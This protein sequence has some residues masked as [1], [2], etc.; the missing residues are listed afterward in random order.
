MNLGSSYYSSD[1]FL[2][3]GYNYTPIGNY[4]IGFL[5]CFMLSEKVMVKTKHYS[6]NVNYEIE[7]VKGDEYVCIKEQKE[8][9]PK[10]IGTEVIL[11]YEEFMNVWNNSIEELTIFIKDTF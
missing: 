4:G 10:S 7:L 1:D 5:S 11:N 2:L 3:K 6:S 8:S 9:R